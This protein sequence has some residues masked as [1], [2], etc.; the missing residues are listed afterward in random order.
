MK[1]TDFFLKLNIPNLPEM[2]KEVLD[3]LKKH[4]EHDLSGTL[5]SE[6]WTRLP[7]DRFPI[8]HSFVSA[9]SK[10]RIYETAIRTVP[11]NFSTDIHVDGVKEDPNHLYTNQ[12][13]KAVSEQPDRSFDDIDWETYPPNSQYVL[14]IPI[15]NY[16]N[17]IN[18]WYNA[19]DKAGKE[20]THYYEREEFPYKFWIN[21]YTEADTSVPIEE[22]L[23][24]KP[25]FIKSD[26]Y[27]NVK[28]YGTATRI[29]LT[30]RILEYKK[31]SSLDQFFDY[32]GLV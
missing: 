25:T 11:P 19:S 27:H 31:Y 2:Q 8:T 17:S 3:Y 14:I 21:F 5:D 20:I 29:V 12:I 9:R 15:S 26:I 13:K 22:V 32:T 1:D 30:M 7:N 16:E 6:T 24:D 23:I 18:Y 10:N 28:N 4:P